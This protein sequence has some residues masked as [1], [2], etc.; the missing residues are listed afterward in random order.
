MNYM[1]KYFAF[2][3][4]II[5]MITTSACVFMKQNDIYSVFWSDEFEYIGYPDE[6]MWS[7]DLRNGCPEDIGLISKGLMTLYDHK[8]C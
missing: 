1:V 7:H 4:L 3:V 6:R 2:Y 8:V 5:L